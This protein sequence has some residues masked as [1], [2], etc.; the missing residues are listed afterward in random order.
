MSLAAGFQ[1]MVG[2]VADALGATIVVTRKVPTSYDSTTG[3]TGTA[4]EQTQ[5][6]RGVWATERNLQ[7]PHTGAADATRDRT[8]YREFVIAAIDVDFVPETG[9]DAVIEGRAYDIERVDPVYVNALVIH[10]KL[11]LEL[12]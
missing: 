7:R 1:Q 12:A 3:T 6:L 2:M 11:M 8:K 4:T 5:T 10:Y 9:D